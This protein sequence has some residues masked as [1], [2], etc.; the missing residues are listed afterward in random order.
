[1]VADKLS[2]FDELPK[3]AGVMASTVPGF[4]GGWPVK[5]C[6]S[7]SAEGFVGTGHVDVGHSPA[8]ACVEEQLAGRAPQDDRAKT[9]HGVDLPPAV[10]WR[11]QHD[12]HPCPGEPQPGVAETGSDPVGP[13]NDVPVEPKAAP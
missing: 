6:W 13:A 11:G 8:P 12:A 10:R 1:M 4:A 9:G 2:R 3:F 7:D 5:V